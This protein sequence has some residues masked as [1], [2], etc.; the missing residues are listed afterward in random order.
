MLSSTVLRSIN[1]GCSFRLFPLTSCLYLPYINCT[2]QAAVDQICACQDKTATAGSKI[3]T[4]SDFLTELVR[5]VGDQSA[6]IVLEGAERLREEGT[7]LQVLW[8]EVLKLVFLFSGVHSSAR[9]I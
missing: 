3:D 2:L 9:I 1:L 7:L 8:A 5:V 4:V 6:V